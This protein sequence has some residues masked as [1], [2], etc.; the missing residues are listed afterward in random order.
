[1]MVNSVKLFH[2][3]NLVCFVVEEKGK[4]TK[5]AR[6]NFKKFNWSIFML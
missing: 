2:L 3:L 5:K 6:L 1:M 4:M